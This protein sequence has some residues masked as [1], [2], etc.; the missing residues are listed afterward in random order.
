VEFDEYINSDVNKDLSHKD[1]DQDQDL[2]VK[3]Q[4]KDK[5]LSAKDQDQDKD[6]TLVLKESLGQEQGLTSLYINQTTS[7]SLSMSHS[8][9]QSLQHSA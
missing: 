7:T 8:Q 5:D 3:D 4:D 9:L 1:K 6:F 2:T